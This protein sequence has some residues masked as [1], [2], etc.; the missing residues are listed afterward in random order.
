MSAELPVSLIVAI[1]Q[2]GVIGRDGG[3]PWRLSTDL[4]RF[5]ADTMGNPVIM[6]RK[7]Y[8]SIGKPLSGRLN[9][10]VTRNEHWRAAGVEN[11]SSLQDAIVL[12]RAHCRKSMGAREICVIGGGQI[13]AEALPL[14][15]RLRVTHIL[16]EI[17]GD[18]Q[19]P[20]I[21]PAIWSQVSFQD[22]PSGDRDSHPTRYAI[23]ERI[24]K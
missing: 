3:M 2:N 15:D 11:V 10:V 24:G 8:D 1:S 20:R 16:A 18:T 5:K 6:G 21:N 7:T 4:K 12:A 13:Y 19:F 9:I 23:Y 17:D 22:F 14:A